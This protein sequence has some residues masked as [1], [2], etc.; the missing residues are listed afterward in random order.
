MP[1][2]SQAQ[3]LAD[4]LGLASPPVALAFV[5]A[6]PAS[7]DRTTRHVPS[8]CTFWRQAEQG[9][10]YA[11][12]PEHAECPIGVLTMGFELS[13][14]QQPGAMQLIQSM[15]NLHYLSI[16]EVAALPKVTKPHQGIVYGP[17]ADMPVPPDA[18]LLIVNAYQ[19]MLVAEAADALQLGNTAGQVSFGRP[20]CS[21][22]PRA[23]ASGQVMQSLGCIGARTYV[24]LDPQE[25]VVVVPGA[26]L[27]A[28]VDR[29]A[30]IVAAN[31]TLAEFHAN[32]KREVLGV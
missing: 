16:D 25:S 15:C 7:V 24:G 22:I 17:L 13:E 4:L 3:Q 9:V 6:Q 12:A 21:V 20:A 27:D 18:V 31:R 30:T 5:E 10:F 19:A 2:Q 32:R 14:A 1:Y 28:L 8:A 29:L 26:R 23:L 11:E